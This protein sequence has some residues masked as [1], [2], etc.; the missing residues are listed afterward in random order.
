MSVLQECGIGRQASEE[1]PAGGSSSPDVALDNTGAG[2]R[3]LVFAQLKSLLE[4]VERDVLQPGGISFLR[5]DGRS[6]PCTPLGPLGKAFTPSYCHCVMCC[7]CITYI[8]LSY[9]TLH[10]VTLH[11]I[12]LFCITPNQSHRSHRIADYYMT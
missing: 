11:H 3:V 2:H 12:V 4:L 8:M 6:A 9:V 5:L 1:S 7:A 10:C